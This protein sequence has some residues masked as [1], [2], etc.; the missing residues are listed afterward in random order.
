MQTSNVKSIFYVLLG[1]AFVTGA[2]F[3][4]YEQLMYYLFQIFLSWAFFLRFLILIGLIFTLI[5]FFQL[6]DKLFYGKQLSI[7]FNE[8]YLEFRTARN[9]Y[10]IPYEQLNWLTLTKKNEVYSAIAV[11]SDQSLHFLLGSWFG[12]LNPSEFENFINA[13]KKELKKRGFE[14]KL[15]K[16]AETKTTVIR[17]T[18][19][20]DLSEYL[21]KENKSKKRTFIFLGIF[22]LIVIIIVVSILRIFNSDGILIRDGETIGSSYY[23]KFQNKIYFLKIGEGYFLLPEANP[24]TFKAL[25]T[26][27][28]IY[29]KVGADQQYAYWQDHKLSLLNPETSIY[30]GGDY[31]KDTRN[32]YFRDQHLAH[33]DVATFEALKHS[34]Y[35]TP[36]YYFAKDKKKVYY[37]TIP[38]TG[39]ESETAQSFDNSS[40]YVRDH[41]SVFY[42]SDFL[43][44]LVASKAKVYDE[45]DKRT[46]YATDGQHHYLNGEAIPKIADNKY[47][48]TT[49]IDFSTFK[50]LIPAGKGSFLYLFGDAL[51]LY[52]YDE[53]YAKMVMVYTFD[54]PVS[55][56]PLDKGYFTDGKFTYT[57]NMRRIST[58]SKTIA[59]TR[60]Y[61]SEILRMRDAKN[62]VVIASYAAQQ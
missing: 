1:F 32:A 9:T 54:Q 13:L 21:N 61:D 24:S 52:F 22:F 50:L 51:H 39:L 10:A 3:L 11:Q 47:F 60:G 40:R 7:G 17:E 55:I 23:Q 41:R 8:K 62:P 20:K 26:E 16:G 44:G 31:T 33:V 49:Q 18:F 36:V 5:Y 27:G 37:K 38:L 45:E 14:Y 28:E 43:K 56:R 48:G 46:A 53:Y 57:L 58:R 6:A 29:S 2:Y 4:L 35:N 25:Q 34:Q 12:N 15:A 19:C 59:T 42:E 30:L